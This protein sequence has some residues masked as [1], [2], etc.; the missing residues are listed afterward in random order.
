MALL[1]AHK[2]TAL[3]TAFEMPSCCL[4]YAVL[5]LLCFC[6]F[7]YAWWVLLDEWSSVLKL[8]CCKCC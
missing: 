5:Y 3:F 8:R 4:D 2:P 6:L 7:Q 1:A